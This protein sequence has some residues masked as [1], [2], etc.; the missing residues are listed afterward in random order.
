MESKAL[1]N[2]RFSVGRFLV[3]SSL[4]PVPVQVS[5]KHSGKGQCTSQGREGRTFSVRGYRTET[6]YFWLL[7]FWLFIVPSSF[8]L[9]QKASYIPAPRAFLGHRQALRKRPVHTRGTGRPPCG[10]ES[11]IRFG[12]L[13]LP[14]SVLANGRGPPKLMMFSSTV[15]K[16]IDS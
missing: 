8:I 10:T 5:S 2:S 16:T 4:R 6:A 15:I 11:R 1:G 3:I 13:L 12:Q 9:C 14:N 7:T